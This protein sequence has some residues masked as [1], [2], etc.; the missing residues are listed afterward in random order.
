MPVPSS[1]SMALKKGQPKYTD[2]KQIL[3]ELSR[4]YDCEP[5]LNEINYGLPD[6]I[7]HNKFCPARKYSKKCLANNL[8]KLAF[9]T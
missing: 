3:Y 1:N 8:S 4:E 7:H 2:R 9:K 6:R 5:R